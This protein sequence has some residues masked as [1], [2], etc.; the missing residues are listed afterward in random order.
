MLT[1]RFGVGEATNSESSVA[2]SEI[3]AAPNPLKFFGN[4]FGETH[5]R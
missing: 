2:E 4:Q 1:G 5:G 3:P